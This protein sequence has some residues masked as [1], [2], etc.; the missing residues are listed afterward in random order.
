MGLRQLFLIGGL[1]ERLIYLT[2]GL[3]VLLAFIGVKLILHA[4]HENNLPFINGGTTSSGAGWSSRPG[5]R[6]R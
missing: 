6:C 4:L 5:S 3:A 2:D 1:M